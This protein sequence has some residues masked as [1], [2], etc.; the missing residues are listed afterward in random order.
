LLRIMDA[1]DIACVAS[2]AAKSRAAKSKS[3][4]SSTSQQGLPSEVGVADYLE[5]LA[6]AIADPVG[7]DFMAP[8]V[9]LDL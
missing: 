7:P 1:C 9:A 2:R 6:A 8:P 3:A 4:R 5:I